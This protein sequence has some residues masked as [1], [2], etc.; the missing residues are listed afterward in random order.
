MDSPPGHAASNAY[1]SRS[2]TF[3]GGSPRTNR[4]TFSRA[5]SRDRADCSGT[6]H[7]TCG[8][9]TTFGSSWNGSAN[10]RP[11]P[12]GYC[13]QTSRAATNAGFAFRCLYK[14]RSRISFPRAML[15]RTASRFKSP[16]SRAPMISRVRRG[17]GVDS[18]TKS[19]SP[20]GRAEAA[21]V[22]PH[23]T[24]AARGPRRRAVRGRAR[25]KPA[26]D[27]DVDLGRAAGEGRVI[28]VGADEDLGEGPELLLRDPTALLR[29][30]DREED[31]GPGHRGA[32]PRGS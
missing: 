6:A 28:E 11:S 29:H 24:G 3:R 15:I 4:A 27:E 9:I 8:V 19:R 14:S 26:C 5:A 7:A 22:P 18:S 32:N 13:H 21:L 23:T 1:S 31:D 30:R 17:G 10:G 12:L 2:T 20:R 16:S 25:G